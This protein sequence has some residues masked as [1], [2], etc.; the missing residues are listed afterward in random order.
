[1]LALRISTVAIKAVEDEIA[2][3]PLSYIDRREVERT[4]ETLV[5]ERSALMATEILDIIYQ[6]A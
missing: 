5:R 1:M 6:R 4:V 2:R 3:Q